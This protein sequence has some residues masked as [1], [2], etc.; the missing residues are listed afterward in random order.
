MSEVKANKVSGFD[1]CKNP[2]DFFITP[3][4]PA[5]EGMRRLSFKCPCGC[6]D[7][8]GIRIREDGVQDGKAWGW[9]KNE[10]CPT[11]TP[12]IAINGNHWHGYLTAGVFKSC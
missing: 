7:L 6:G 1:D 11:T 12:S 4:N 3:P 8:C 9:D 2:G 10:D 5:E